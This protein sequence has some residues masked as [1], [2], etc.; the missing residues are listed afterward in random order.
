MVDALVSLT[1]AVSE[2]W[3]RTDGATRF[4]GGAS[5]ELGGACIGVFPSSEALLKREKGGLRGGRL[6]MGPADMER[7][8][9]TPEIKMAKDAGQDH[10]L[11]SKIQVAFIFHRYSTVAFHWTFQGKMAIKYSDQPD[12]Q[13]VT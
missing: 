6:T 12:R 7:N 11:L 3:A 9:H 4:G 8:L 2:T 10:F 13:R 5:V 1:G